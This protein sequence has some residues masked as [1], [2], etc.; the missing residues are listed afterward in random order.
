MEKKVA[1]IDTEGGI[2]IDR[3]KQLAKNDFDVISSNIIVF[4]PNS[5]QEQSN[6]LKTIESWIN[7]NEDDIDLIIID[8]AVAL[9][10]LKEGKK[11]NLLNRELGTQMVHCHGWLVNMILQ[12]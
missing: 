3:V 11:S 9:Y 2:S 6:N 4:E 12:L 5:F 7:S 1:Y 8:S 10:R